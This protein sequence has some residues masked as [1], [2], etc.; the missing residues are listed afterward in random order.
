[1]YTISYTGT[2]ATYGDPHYKTFDGKWFDFNGICK[3][4][5]A[6]D[7]ETHLFRVTTENIAC[8]TTKDVSC[9]KSVTLQLNQSV[10]VL[11]QGMKVSVEK[12]A[13]LLPYTGPGILIRKVRP[14]Y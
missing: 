1:M 13:V 9:A 14:V 7:W 12:K 4:V 6:Q 10:I 11:N 3:Y 8:S 5:L 2:C